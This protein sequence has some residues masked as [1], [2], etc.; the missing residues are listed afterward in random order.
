[1]S[2]I[3]VTVRGPTKLENYTRPELVDPKGD[4]NWQA[5]IN[6]GAWVGHGF[7]VETDIIIYNKIIDNP[8]DEQKAGFI[9]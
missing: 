7:D 4:C 2:V 3:D 8:L 5:S 6:R 9:Y 1:M